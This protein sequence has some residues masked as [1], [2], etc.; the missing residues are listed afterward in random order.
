M[1]AII[2]ITLWTSVGGGRMIIFLA[3]LQGVPQELYEAADI[4]GAGHLAR[5]LHI[6][7]P[8]ISPTIFFNLV[9]GVI[10]ALQVFTTAFITTAGGPGRATWFYALH[11]YTAAFQHFD[12]GYASAL[13]WV[14]FVVLLVFTLVQ[15]RAS[16][17]WVFYAGT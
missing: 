12:M 8:I 10:G 3:G 9:L 14:L 13:S 1:P 11:I 16:D 5:F 7:L 6:T 2:L 15:I 17:R 4:D